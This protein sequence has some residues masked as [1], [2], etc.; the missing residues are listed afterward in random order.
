[1]TLEPG[2]KGGAEI[3]AHPCIVVHNVDYFPVFVEDAGCS[4]RGIALGRYPF[5]PVVIRI[6]RVLDF[7]LFKPCVLPRGLVKMAVYADVFLHIEM[8]SDC[9][10]IAMMRLPICLLSD[11]LSGMSDMTGRNTET[12]TLAGGC[13]WCLEAVFKELKGVVQVVSGYTGGPTPNPTYRE[14]CSGTTGHTEAVQVIFDPEQISYR[15]ILQVFFTIHDPTTLNRQGPDKGTQYRSAVFFHDRQ[16]EA[17]VSEVIREISMAK[18]WDDPIVTEVVP[19]TAFY[20]AEDYHQ[21]YFDL[22]GDEAYCRVIIAPK[23][24]KFRKQFH[25]RLKSV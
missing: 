17:T 16:Q 21:D 15:D 23:V 25:D 8:I 14:V 1:M 5:I 9:R 24:A 19:F 4:V 18:I 12:A 13:F 20:R 3:K 7:D 6:G 22:H 2:E 10:G 11:M